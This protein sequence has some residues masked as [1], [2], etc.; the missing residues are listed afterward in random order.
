MDKRTFATKYS[1]AA[2]DWDLT[3][4][5]IYDEVS[6]IRI[7]GS[8][9]AVSAGDY[10]FVGDYRGVI[11]D[12]EMDHEILTLS[13]RDMVTIFDRSLLPPDTSPVSSIE[14]WIKGQI[15]WHY[16][17]QA[18]DAYRLP[19]LNVI[20]ET[21]T[22]G[23]TT[24]DNGTWN[25]KSYLSKVRRLYNIHTSFGVVNNTLVVR[26]ARRGRQ[27]HKVF[28]DSAQFELIEEAY[29]SDTI[30]KITTVAADTG[31]RKDW[32]LLADGTVTDA[33]TP[34][35]RVDGKWEILSVQTEA[36]TEQAVRDKFAGNSKSH[37]I[38]FA[39]DREYPFYDNLLIRTRRGLVVTSYISAIRQEMSREKLIYKSGELRTTLTEKIGEKQWH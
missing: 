6:Q 3:L 14:A 2:L 15:D 19:Y 30:S 11:R 8:T 33:Y 21:N 25:I 1:G 13:C 4:Q 5:S 36:D 37:M 38:A 20:A 34:D 23:T 22:P 24:P 12:I 31:A 32:Y 28:L 35:N 27:E 16:T 7:R 17:K 10:V 29:S 9:E 18:D 39:T 26:I